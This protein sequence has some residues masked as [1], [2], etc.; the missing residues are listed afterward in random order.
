MKRP[1]ITSAVIAGAWASFTVA[2]EPTTAPAIQ[3][4][5][6]GV[7]ITQ[8][9]QS[10]GMEKCCFVGISTSPIRADARAQ[11]DLPRGVGLVIDF[12]EP[13]SPAEKAGL[14]PSDVVQKLDDQWI[15]NPQQLTVL[16]RM[17]QAGESVTMNVFRKGKP[18]D[19]KVTLGEKMLPVADPAD[20][21]TFMLQPGHAAVPALPALPPQVMQ[22]LRGTPGV[23]FTSSMNSSD[24]EH[25]I[26]LS[27]NDGKKTAIVKDKD[28]KTLFDGPINT[29]DERAKIPEAVR[30]KIEKIE[31]NAVRMGVIP[32]P[33]PKK[34]PGAEPK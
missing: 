19:L 20:P 31:D 24:G 12:V 2:A 3:D 14:R 1:L 26:N 16:V 6:D 5:K 7:V 23:K 25:T 30:T 34:M 10:P 15:I 17:H 9:A 8:T 27:I 4:A 28:G 32:T 13:D 33:E 29:D 21:M 11:L 22:R 18:Q